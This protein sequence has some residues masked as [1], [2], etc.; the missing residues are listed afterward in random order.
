VV[1]FTFGVERDQIVEIRGNSPDLYRG[2]I[3]LINQVEFGGGTDMYSG[4]VV[5]LEYLQA[6]CSSEQLPAVIVMTDGMSEGRFREFKRAWERYYDNTGYRIPVYS[7]TFGNADESQLEDIA[8][9]TLGD[10]FDGTSDLWTAFAK[11]KGNN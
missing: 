3:E 6:R 8:E 11:A 2:K 7:I 10:V 5:G 9:L 4:I 1:P